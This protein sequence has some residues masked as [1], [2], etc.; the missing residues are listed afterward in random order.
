MFVGPY[1]ILIYL[2]FL[3]AGSSYLPSQIL[4]KGKWTQLIEYTLCV[5]AHT[6]RSVSN[7]IEVLIVCF[8]RSKFKAWPAVSFWLKMLIFALAFFINNDK[9]HNSSQVTEWYLHPSERI[10]VTFKA[11]YL[12][13][14]KR[15]IQYL[16]IIIKE[17]KVLRVDV[18][19]VSS[20]FSKLHT[21]FS[22]VTDRCTLTHSLRMFLALLYF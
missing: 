5:F 13:K 15:E 7:L 21:N 12:T 19:H 1:G 8:P 11:A 6:L 10:D 16:T 2:S 22:V 9:L 20:S 14:K 4:S 3:N 17:K 18:N